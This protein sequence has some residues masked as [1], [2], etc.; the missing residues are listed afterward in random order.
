MNIDAHCALAV[1]IYHSV[2][3]IIKWI[4]SRC[5]S[6]AVQSGNVNTHVLR[7]TFENKSDRT[8]VHTWQMQFYQNDSCSLVAL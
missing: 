8:I 5:N 7:L 3:A 4:F 2:A 6:L 1:Q